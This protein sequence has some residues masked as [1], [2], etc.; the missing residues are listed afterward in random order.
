MSTLTDLRDQLALA[1]KGIADIIGKTVD[2]HP[3]GNTTALF[4]GLSCIVR[5]VK[6][7]E[8]ELLSLHGTFA[9]K[10]FEIPKQSTLTTLIIEPHRHQ[11]KYAGVYWEIH[12]VQTDDAE[13]AGTTGTGN[14]GVAIVFARRNMTEVGRLAE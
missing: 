9:E 11:L 6:Q 7:R 5:D 13:V 1:H 12:F 8:A 10:V 3:Q 4:S 14:A 2:L